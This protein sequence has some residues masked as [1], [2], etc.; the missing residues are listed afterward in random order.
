MTS[1]ML[2]EKLLLF[3]DKLM[4]HLPRDLRLN[5][6][7]DDLDDI[8]SDAS[9]VRYRSCPFCHSMLSETKD[10]TWV[11]DSVMNHGGQA[12]VF[13]EGSNLC[14]YIDSGGPFCR[15]HGYCLWQVHGP[16]GYPVGCKNGRID[17][18]SPRPK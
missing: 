7:V 5:H 2:N 15:W 6:L 11:C 17:D 8:I 16:L 14:K 10:H 12:L 13:L 4:A 1:S 3:H 9:G 18:Q